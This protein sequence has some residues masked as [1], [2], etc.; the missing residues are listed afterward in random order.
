MLAHRRKGRHLRSIPRRTGNTVRTIRICP[1]V[2]QKVPHAASSC[3]LVRICVRCEDIEALFARLPHFFYIR[4]NLARRCAL[5]LWSLRHRSR[6]Y[7]RQER[8]RRVVA[9]QEAIQIALAG[10]I[11]ESDCS[12][13]TAAAVFTSPKDSAC[14]R[15]DDANNARAIADKVAQQQATTALLQATADTMWQSGWRA[16]RS[17]EQSNS[18]DCTRSGQRTDRSRSWKTP[19]TSNPRQHFSSRNQSRTQS[20][21]PPPYSNENEYAQSTESAQAPTK[22][23]GVTCF[24]CG[25]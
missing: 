1:S 10:E 25:K 7:L 19:R 9:W 2:S 24:N 3:R 13:P 6:E 11:A 12:K 8:A 23:I 18:N 5:R 20:R 21:G 16:I 4:T 22:L 17:Q 15:E 14:S